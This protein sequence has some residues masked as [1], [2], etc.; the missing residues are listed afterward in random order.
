MPVISAFTPIV[1]VPV[2]SVY[3]EP[4]IAPYAIVPLQVKL[5]K[6]K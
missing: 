3:I 6:L 1:K 4:A 5:F 2:V